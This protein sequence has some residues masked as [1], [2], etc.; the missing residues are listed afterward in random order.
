MRMTTLLLLLLGMSVPAASAQTPQGTTQDGESLYAERCA[1]CHESGVPRAANREGL[2]RLSPDTIR[3][4]LT[5]GTMRAQGGE[6][7]PTQI[8]N[9]ARLLGAAPPAAGSASVDN[10]CAAS[11]ASSFAN[12]LDRPRW[13]GWG[14]NLSQHRFQPADAARLPADQVPRLKLKWA[15]GLP[16]VNRAFAQPTVVGGRVFVGSANGIVYSLNAD[17]GCQYLVVQGRRP[18]P[19]SDYDRTRQRHH[20]GKMDW[21]LR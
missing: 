2:R 11:P 6:L 15:F 13:N 10:G 9:L 3:L 14:A 16:G 20:G 4:A 17:T 8:D 5:S 1:K 18:R 7:T 19:H 21:L 12:A